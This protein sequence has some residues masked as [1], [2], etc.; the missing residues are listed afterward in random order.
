MCFTYDDLTVGEED[1]EITEK[2]SDL[3]LVAMALN[4]IADSLDKL[5]KQYHIIETAGHKPIAEFVHD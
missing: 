5:R 1:V 3:A 2:P 4:R